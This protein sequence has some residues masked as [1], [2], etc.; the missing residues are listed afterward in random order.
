MVSEN[1]V[2][3]NIFG[4]KRDEFTG[5]WRKLLKVKLYAFYPSLNIIE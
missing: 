2:L 1:K 5:E 4:A 3:R